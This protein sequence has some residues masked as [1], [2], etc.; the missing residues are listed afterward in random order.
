M[1]NINELTEDEAKEIFNFVYPPENEKFKHYWFRE[2]KMEPTINE[3][4]SQ[5]ITFGF[6]PIIGILGN[7]GQDNIIIHFDNT[8]AVLWLYKHGYDITELLER[9]S[10]FTE[11][12]GDFENFS[13]AIHWLDEKRKHIPENKKDLYNL[14]YVLK[15]LKRY[16]E[17]Y[18]YKDYE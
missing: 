17:K 8:K 2:L 15:E 6:R 5:R 3:D 18:Y 1:K 16:N 13:F 14:E 9:N 7:N 11:M 12:E 4:G 10:H